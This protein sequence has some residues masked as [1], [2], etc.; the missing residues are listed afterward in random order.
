MITGCRVGP[1]YERPPIQTPAQHRSGEPTPTAASFGEQKW[2][3]VFGDES[4]RKLIT[5]ALAANYDVKIAAQRVLEA[6]GRLTQTKSG[7]W[8]QLNAGGQVNKQSLPGSSL[9]TIYGLGLLSWQIDLF[10]QVL[11]AG[12]AAQ[13]EL[14]SIQENQKAVLQTLVASVAN[15]YFQLRS[16]DGQLTFAQESLKARTDSLRLVTA[17]QQGGVA[18]KL[19]VDQAQTLVASAAATIAS[20]Q[21]GI[22]QTENYIS[23]LLGRT[24]GPIERGRAF[25]AQPEPPEV[26][27]GLPSALLERRPDLRAAEQRL[28]AA[29]ARIGVAKAA[30]FPSIALTGGGGYQSV[31]LEG[32]THRKGGVSMFGATV[33]I[34]IFDAGARIGNYKAT[35]AQKE[36]LALGYQQTVLNAFREVSDSLIGFQKAKEYRAQQALLASTLRD[37]SRLSDLRYKGGVTSYLEVLDTERQRLDAEQAL[38]DAYRA[39]LAALVKL[40][41][42]LGGGWQ[43]V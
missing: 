1:K 21:S 10:G 7:L 30:F 23:V 28:I 9:S 18:S 42:A 26:P 17:R 3:E 41:I 15:G 40:Y 43:P 34:P 19:D 14:L 38:A 36:Q 6:Q 32:V 16:L 5:E 8:P 25:D 27:A 20:L 37:Q 2:F 12:D 22:E 24:P 13:A 31:D 39:E 11:S 33:D 35:K 29:N 4:L